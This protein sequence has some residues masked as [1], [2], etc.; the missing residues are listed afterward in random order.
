[1]TQYPLYA[2]APKA[3]EG[4][5]AN[6]IRSLGGQ[7]VKEKLA[8][9]AFDGDLALAYRVCLWSRVANRIFL[10]LSS[11]E[12][13]SQQDLYDG[14]KRINWFEHMK[15]DDSLA[16]S[17]SSKNSP[18]INNTHFG[19]QKVKDA[20]V[21]QMRAKFNKRP[22]VET[23][24]PSLRVNVY[25][26]NDLAQ[27][28]LDLS[29]ESLHK[30][31]FRDV[32]IAA[33]IKENLAAA[34][35]LRAGWPKIAEQGGTLLDPMCGSGTML[36]EGALI[37]AD[38]A[39]GLQRDYF[40]FLGWKKHDAELWQGLL[41][42]ARQRR[43]AGLAKLPTIVG[44]DQD[45]RTV[46][47]AVQ[48]VENAGL[49]GKIHIE[50]RD[51]GDAAAAESWP[52]GL[53]AC[54]PPYGERLGDEAE[55]AA[56]YRRFGE[57][58]KQRFAGWQAAMIISDPE[59]GFRLG[60]RSQKPITL[61]NGALECKLLR[62]NIEERAFFEPK[63]KSQQE[64]AE[65]I[66]RRAQAE[67]VDPQADMFGNRLR[68]NLKKL[69]KW[70]KQNNVH[71][72]RLYDADLPEYA[73]AVDVYQGEQIW[74]NVQEYESPKTIDPAK[75]NQRL[76]GAMAEI[77]KVLEIPANQV[78]LKIRRKQK[79]TDQYEKQ[80]DSGRFL[81]VQEGGCQFWVNFEDYLDTG[82]FLDHRPMR[83][84]IQQ[85]AKGKRFLNLFAYT[86][87]AT[88]HAAVGGA[89]ASVTVDM[90]NTYLDW[91]KRN[92]ELNGIRGDHKLVRADCPKW[93]A[94][95]A[96][97]KNRPQFDLIFLDPPTFSNSKKMDEAFDIQS[98]HVALL[99]N[100]AALLAPSGVLYF[101]T[102]FRRFKLDREALA[103]LH[104]EDITAATIPDDFARD[105]K[106]HY[107]W[108][109]SR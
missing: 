6:E 67:Q 106:I 95:Q 22:S 54:N 61:F 30:R 82:L 38:I 104:F 10:P 100:A 31:G 71:C 35:L 91:A 97:L 83:L 70:A 15:P 21:D 1:M 76:A 93:L 92:F 42:E 77:P 18:A 17:F 24:R 23:E 20:I 51:I 79:A 88:V 75:A 81:V 72:Y 2:T 103:G 108:R 86:G 55:T 94:E 36:L 44:F 109:I 74:V 84:R 98:D 25:L 69:A 59:L 26:H 27:L 8:G 96:A 80:G 78:F 14:V 43:E 64:R 105:Q 56:L 68:K 16:V 32:S 33:P 85:E 53:I 19:A 99:K 4:I 89:V 65:S 87:S 63:A 11:F 12:V 29:G 3:L 107:C 52:K 102:N 58:L 28:S 5:L 66:W 62:F 34:I 45:R 101:S 39:P 73:V 50:K 40:G 47:T 13:K 60:I 90:S 9:V 48:H 41:D 46:A 49:S 7:N 37:A 57:V